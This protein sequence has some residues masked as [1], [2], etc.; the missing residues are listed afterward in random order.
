MKVSSFFVTI[1]RVTPVTNS[2]GLQFVWVNMA[3]LEDMEH[4]V[5]RQF[6]AQGKSLELSGFSIT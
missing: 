1:L 3:V 2:S 6:A 4:C 5:F